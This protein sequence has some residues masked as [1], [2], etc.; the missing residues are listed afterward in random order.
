M[1]ILV[2]AS[3][4][5]YWV[6]IK[7]MKVDPLDA[8]LITGGAFILIGLFLEV[9]PRWLILVLRLLYHKKPLGLGGTLYKC[10]PR[11]FMGSSAMTIF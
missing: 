9:A 4:I 3:W 2:G 8:I 6:L 5:L 11:Y 10:S 1:S 7:P